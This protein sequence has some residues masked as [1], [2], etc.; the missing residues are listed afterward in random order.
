M[1]RCRLV[2]DVRFWVE[3]DR[4]WRCPR[5]SVGESRQGESYDAHRRFAHRS[6][7][8]QANVTVHER[9]ISLEWNHSRREGSPRCLI[10]FDRISR[11]FTFARYYV[12]LARL[13][14]GMFCFPAAAIRMI[15]LHQP[16]EDA[17][18]VGVGRGLG[19]QRLL[20]R[21]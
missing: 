20:R 11:A 1:R 2:F 8:L 3:N 17:L 15:A 10:G 5:S 12:G 9:R 16:V 18:S 4:R 7:N 19:L 21:V 6:V 14:H 13:F